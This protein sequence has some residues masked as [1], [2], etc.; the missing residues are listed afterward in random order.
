MCTVTF[1]PLSSNDFILTSNRDEQKERITI[2]PKK[3]IEDGVELVFPKD[4]TAGGTWIG[5][6]SQN[7]LVCV[8][9]GAYKKHKRK[10]SYIKSRGVIA[11][12][13]LKDQHLHQY[14]D[15][16][17]LEGIEPFTI[18][19]VDWNNEELN[20]FELIWDEGKKYFLKLK[21]E[22]KIWSSSTLY[23]DDAK[24]IRK[25]WFQKWVSENEFSSEQILQ[26][27][28]SEIGDKEQSVLM[29][30]SYVETV[31]ITSVKKENNIVEMLYEDVVHS[32]KEQLFF[33]L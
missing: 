21:N 24:I 2:S 17:D 11:K 7:R 8:L 30:R 27:H 15:K 28:H 29:K 14:I 25:N 9:N 1:L 33:N 22:P 12:E 31:S 18:V 6:S 13:I 23:S 32:K 3:Y 16:L 5:T 19:I 20:L 10:D 4:K 26:F